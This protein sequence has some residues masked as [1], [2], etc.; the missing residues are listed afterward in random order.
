M[1]YSSAKDAQEILRLTTNNTIA[2]C[3]LAEC[4]V[5]PVFA[6]LPVSFRP[7]AARISCSVPCSLL[8]T[9]RGSLCSSARLSLRQ[10]RPRSTSRTTSI[11]TSPAAGRST[12]GAFLSAIGVLYVF[13]A[14]RGAVSTLSLYNLD[15]IVNLPLVARCPCRLF[16]HVSLHQRSLPGLMLHACAVFYVLFASG[17]CVAA[18]SPPFSRL[19]WN[20]S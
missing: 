12:L 1:V 3:I 16:P 8:Q 9:W 19:F 4:V 20:A 5:V 6:G 14:R 10:C 17:A 13:A 15:L 18:A 2:T 11:P 7:A